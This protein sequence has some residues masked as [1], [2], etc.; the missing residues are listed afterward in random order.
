MSQEE[1]H[2]KSQVYLESHRVRQSLLEYFQCP[3]CL[4]LFQ[5]SSAAE[6]VVPIHRRFSSLVVS[7]EVVREYHQLSLEVE[8]VVPSFLRLRK[9][10]YVLSLEVRTTCFTTTTSYTT[11]AAYS[12]RCVQKPKLRAKKL[13]LLL[14]TSR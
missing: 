11:A 5:L 6:E 2:L 10:S 1:T 8:E 7:E 3:R 12:F 14:E 4:S 9:V 13:L